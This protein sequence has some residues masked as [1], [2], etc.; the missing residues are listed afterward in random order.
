MLFYGEIYLSYSG[1]FSQIV[2]KYRKRIYKYM[3]MK[4]ERKVHIL[5]HYVVFCCT[6]RILPLVI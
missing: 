6:Q 1:S 2:C 3:R 5:S 4:E